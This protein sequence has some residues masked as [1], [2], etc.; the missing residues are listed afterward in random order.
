MSKLI[1]FRAEDGQGAMRNETPFT[2]QAK[3][4]F[5]SAILNTVPVPPVAG[6]TVLHLDV[7]KWQ[8]EID[9]DVM[10]SRGI[11]AVW[12]KS[13]Q[14][15]WPDANFEQNVLGATDA[16]LEIGFYHFTDPAYCDAI[17]AG[18]HCASMTKGIGR[19][20]VTMDCE[21]TGGY[22]APQ[23]LNYYMNWISG[24]RSIDADRKIDL[25][26]R[27]SFFN[28]FVARSD[29]WLTNSV[30][31]WAARYHLGLSSPW[32]DGN[33]EPLDWN[34][35]VLKYKRW[36]YSADGNGLGAY[37]GCSSNSVDVNLFFGDWDDF[38]TA[39]GLDGE[40]PPPP[41]PPNVKVNEMQ[42]FVVNSRLLNCRN[43]PT[44]YSYFDGKPVEVIAQAEYGDVLTQVAEV[45]NIYAP[46]KYNEV[47]AKCLMPDGETV[48]W[49]AVVHG[50]Y[51]YLKTQKP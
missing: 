12:I 27:L 19:L 46:G 13:D 43:Y 49:F 4:R 41:P 9:F 29:Y 32:S 48:G 40:L 36:Q 17:V 35:Q 3:A 23:L 50:G 5:S 38:R 15:K 8:G 11:K 34:P 7:S 20:S 24:F 30:E 6:P 42:K 1:N 21:R 16:G 47:W 51:A 33:Y 25:Y 22:G 39:Y 44:T 28:P 45:Q 2:T 14:G 31:L 10:K 18:N 37:F 26:T